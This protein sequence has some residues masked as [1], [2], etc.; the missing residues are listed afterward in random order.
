MKSRSI[1]GPYIAS[2][3]SAARAPEETSHMP[4]MGNAS[5]LFVGTGIFAREE[6]PGY[7]LGGAMGLILFGVELLA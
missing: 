4:Y 3:P 2:N 5:V 1:L 6:I 7:R